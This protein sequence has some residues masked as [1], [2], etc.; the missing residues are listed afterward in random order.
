MTIE[1]LYQMSQSLGRIDKTS[2]V[3]NVSYRLRNVKFLRTMVL[4]EKADNKLYLSLTPCAAQDSW[5]EFKIS[6]SSLEVWTEHCCG[7]IRLQKDTEE[8]KSYA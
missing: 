3:F 6:S 5:Y 4:E 7:L 1:A 8:G 2:E